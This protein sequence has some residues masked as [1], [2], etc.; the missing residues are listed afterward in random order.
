MDVKELA[1]KRVVL[2]KVSNTYGG[3]WQGPCPSCNGKDRFHVWPAQHEGNGSYWCRGCDKAGDNIQFL[4]DFEGMT[5][6]QACNHLRISIP[7]RPASW[8]PSI[9]GRSHHEFQPV[10]HELPAD[11]WQDRAEKLISWAQGNLEKN[12]EVL[13]WLAG[14]GIGGQVARDFRLGWNPGEDGND[15]YRARNAWGLPEL[16]RDD[17]KLKALWIPVGLVIPYIRDGVI[18]RIRIRRPEAEKRYIVL[19]GS[20]MS[21]MILGR[22]RRS[23]VAVEAELDAI[24]VYANNRLAGAVGL[25]SVSAKPDAETHEILTK[26][27]QILLA[28]DFDEP[29]RKATAWW[30]EQFERCDRW[31]VPQGKDPGEAFKMGTDLDKWI[32]A[33]LPPALTIDDATPAAKSE[34][35]AA[36]RETIAPLDENILQAQLPGAVMELYDLL[37]KNPGV[38]IINTPGRLA[39]LRG[40]KYVGGRINHLVF[41]VAEVMDFISAHGAAEIDWTNFL[42]RAPA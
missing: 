30:K 34:T 40:G 39:V 25:G 9:P 18:H 32:R 21:T 19:P 10:R 15:I 6:R 8:R 42:E 41:Q 36:P 38:K 28:I 5:F 35:K 3:E 33:G 4:I 14:R 13:S 7:E 1:E 11:L 27:L 26:A 2:K 24:A 12:A 31:P 29:G 23:F 16:R 20:S 17:G 37:R 22:D